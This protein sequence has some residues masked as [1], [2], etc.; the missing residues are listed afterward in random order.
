MHLKSRQYISRDCIA[1]DYV[2]T[3]LYLDTE[4]LKTGAAPGG[5]A[6]ASPMIF[7]FFVCLSAQRSVMAMLIPLPHSE[8]LLEPGA[9][10]A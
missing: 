10:P 4:Y 7:F 9:A 8:N 3:K 2:L 1:S 6:I 5:Q